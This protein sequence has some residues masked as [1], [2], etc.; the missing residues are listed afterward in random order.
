MF[1]Q[2]TVFGI[3][4][5]QNLV[6]SY[7][8][9]D[10]R[11]L[12]YCSN[13]NGICLIENDQP[14]CYCLPEWEGEHCNLIR[15][16]N[17]KVPLMS[18]IMTRNTPCTFVPDLCK[19][20][21]VCYLDETTKKLACKCPYPFDGTRCGEYSVCFN[22]CYNSGVCTVEGDGLSKEPKCDCKGTG[23]EGSRCQQQETTTAPP[24]TTTTTITTT[25]GST[26]TDIIC[27]YLPDGYCNSGSCVVE[28]NRARCQ[29]P[30]THTGDQCENAVGGIVVPGQ[31]NPTV[32]PPQPTAT[33]YP[34]QTNPS[35]NPGQPSTVPPAGVNCAQNPCRNN[36]PCYNNGNSYFCYCGSQFSGTNCETLQG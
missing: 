28:N 7:P 25:T 29:C 20:A 24:T 26:T 4:L 27:S 35:I 10:P 1:V 32:N 21:G 19:N 13:E 11:C 16:S 12:N 22:Y 33:L 31:T 15:K 3:L 2:L 8:S 17:E 18:R 14:I 34:G 6:Q 30:S 23:Y 5:C 36:R 9:N